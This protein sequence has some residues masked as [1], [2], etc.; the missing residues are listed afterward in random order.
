MHI[1]H[2]AARGR[3]R[4]AIGVA[5]LLAAL[6]PA[7]APLK[8][9]V[10]V[11][12]PTAGA[13]QG[14][15]QTL[16]T[17]EYF[18]VLGVLYDGDY[19]SAL[20][21]FQDCLR[22]GLKTP[23]SFWIDS[24]CYH[25]MCGETYFQLGQY[26]Q[27][28]DHFNKALQL[29]I[30]FNDW[31]I[32]VKF[33]AVIRPAQQASLRPI[34]WGKPQRPMMIGHFSDS[35]LIQQGSVDQS[36]V[37]ARGGGVVQQATQ[38]PI[39]PQEI[40]RCVCLSLRRRH[41]IL[42]PLAPYDTLTN[43]FVSVMTK[44]PVQPNHWTESWID[45]M[46][47]CAF[48]AIGKDPQAK[49]LLEKSLLAGGTYDHPLTSTALLE[50]GRIALNAGDYDLA[51]KYFEEAGYSGYYFFDPL[52]VEDAFR[53]SVITHILANRKGTYAPLVG[54]IAWARQQDYRQMQ[55]ELLL[56][57]AEL[58]CL[59]NDAKS[60]STTLD[61]ARAVIGRRDMLK[62]RIGAQ[63]N[64]NQAHV[65]YQLGN[66]AAG[67]TAINAALAFAK[68]G[69]LQLFRMGLADRMVVDRSL[70]T[71]AAS[72]V[73]Q[74]LLRDPQAGRWIYDPL[75]TL[76]VLVH[77]HPLYFERWFEVSLER[78]ELDGRKA[79]E[80]ADLWKRH[81][82]LTTQEFGGRLLALRWILES[83]PQA[84]PSQASLQRQALLTQFPAYEQLSQ[85]AAALRAELGRMP[86]IIEDPEQ[87]KVQAAK[88]AELEKASRDQEIMLKVMAVRR[89]PADIVFPPIRTVEEVQKALPKEHAL[90]V[91]FT[92]AR[93]S[94]GF[95]MTDEKFGYWLLPNM[96]DVQKK[97]VAV[98]QGLGNHD[99]N[100]VL[101][102]DDLRGTGWQQD[103][104]E[105]FD[106]LT[107]ESKAGLPYGF[108][109]LAIVPDG[110][111][112]YVPFETL[113]A[114][115]QGAEARSLLEQVRLRYAPTMG[116]AVGDTLPRLDK[117]KALVTVG[118]M[119]P[120]DQDEVAEN[121]YAEFLR[122][123]PQTELLKSRV[124]L[125]ASQAL[126]AG[127]A[128][129]LI[130]FAEIVPGANGPQQ[131]APLRGDKNPPSGT[132]ADWVRLPW[133]GPAQVA[134]PAFHSGA[135]NGMKKVSPA[136][137]GNELF[138]TVTSLMASGARTILIS[139]WRTAGRTS[140]DLTREFMQELPY[141]SASKAWQRSVALASQ[142]P[143]DPSAEPRVRLDSGAGAPAASHPFFWSGYMVV[144]T[145]TEPAASA[146]EAA[147]EVLNVV[148]K[149]D[150]P[151]PVAPA[152]PPKPMPPAGK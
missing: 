68:T 73:F 34:P 88:L 86:I 124:K 5:L 59:N 114:A 76:A 118:K 78:K 39:N 144:D 129:R 148:P 142:N 138:Q 56:L 1:E 57:G 3:R 4:G 75:E 17:D 20:G 50:L 38:R 102:A 81:K 79:L 143:I 108:K 83:P 100:K 63:L 47:G 33:D 37:I 121:A 131:T 22:S 113:H 152:E 87:A 98:L 41:E 23:N 150:G 126:F 92:G 14:F 116:L 8:A 107:K 72:E 13:G 60:A 117:G 42:G 127:L 122:A 53:Y 54:G 106:M 82:F 69:S 104:R 12:N 139:R 91:F 67:D 105:L 26:A 90:L 145:G 146:D 109:E 120:T 18:A 128:D 111:L 2:G 101:V 130:T 147:K 77:P 93:S 28:L 96:Q 70:T 55:T 35:V 61:N 30:A 49:P 94:W 62:A 46:L 9:Q 80:I 115:P 25:T 40:V 134:L 16:P 125:P 133:Q 29:Q 132:L 58:Q 151:K 95:L 136:D 123:V 11:G 112:W 103:S 85:H 32:P 65:Q 64:Y 48:A 27:A 44:R 15:R 74:E 21:G 84:L 19:A 119:Y 52:Q 110:M 135:E 36:H 10:V 6:L 137:A 31:M 149:Q 7:A 66:V 24:I 71:R 45:V 43:Q 140:F 51:T 89:L 141:E 97:L 99:E